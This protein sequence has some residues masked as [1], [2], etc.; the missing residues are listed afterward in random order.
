MLSICIKIIKFVKWCNNL[1]GSGIREGHVQSLP[2]V[3][4][5]NDDRTRA[6]FACESQHQD[7]LCS[8][9]QQTF[10]LA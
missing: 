6:T 5:S 2:N 9:P 10:I 8:D 1:C 4:V 3:T 7:W